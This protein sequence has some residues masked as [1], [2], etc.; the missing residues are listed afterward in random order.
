MGV[1]LLFYQYVDILYPKKIR[2]EQE[3]FCKEH[4]LTGR[5]IVATEGINGTLGGSVE[6]TD[7]YVAW[8]KSQPLFAAMPFKTSEGDQSCFPKLAVKV[9]KEIVNL[10]LDPAE[11]HFSQAGQHLSPEAFH[12]AVAQADDNTVLIDI[13]NAY[14]ARVGRFTGAVIPPVN[15]SREFPAYIDS[16]VD[17]LKD[18]K[19]LMYCTGGVRCERVSAYFKKKGIENVYQLEGGIHEYLQKYPDGFFRGVNYVFDGRMGLKT[20]DDV[21]GSCDLCNVPCE[22]FNNCLNASC[23]KHFIA[24]QPCIEKYGNT[25]SK[26]CYELLQSGAVKARPPLRK[27]RAEHAV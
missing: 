18:K 23:N 14:E 13:R 8:M 16:Q 21:L 17:A 22:E 4:N 3:A 27:Y 19:V 7:R 15:R 24:C 12:D 1:V 25:C 11:V 20:N 10:G 5:I 9:K 26:T 2:D 6:S